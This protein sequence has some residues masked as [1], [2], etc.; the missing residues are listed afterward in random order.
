MIV[1]ESPRE[2]RPPEPAG[3][4][5]VPDL[6]ALLDPRSIAVVGASGD[7]T[8]IGGRPIHFLQ[9]HGYAGDI[10]PVNLRQAE[11]QGLAS[12]RTI[13]DVP[14]A[15]DL[16]I[17]SVPSAQVVDQLQLC[18]D[19]GARFAIVFSSG[20]AE[21][22]REGAAHQQRITD[23]A[24][25]TGLRVL[26]PNSLGVMNVASKVFC[27]FGVAPSLPLPKPGGVSIVSQ[28]GAFGTFTFA[29]GTLRGLPMG[30][31][32]TTGNEA[33]LDFADCVAWLATDPGTQVI[34]GYMEGCKDGRKLMRALEL[35][36]R[37]AKPVVVMKV[38]RTQA[39]A[40][41]AQS[42]TAALAGSDSVFDAVLRQCGA[43]RAATVDEFF[44]TGYACLLGLAPRS[45]RLGVITVSGGAGVLMADAAEEVGLD[46]APLSHE[47]QSKMRA[48]LPFA[49]TRNPVDVTGQSTNDP[50]L[51][52]SFLDAMVEDGDF[53]AIA[54]FQALGGL[55]PEVAD[56]LVAG[57]T[58][59]RAAHPDTPLYISM[60]SE[61]AVTE[62]LE[63]LNIPVFDEPTRM[64]RAIAALAALRRAQAA[65]P[66]PD[67]TLGA[68]AL[69]TAPANEAQASRLLHL[70]GVPMAPFA[71]ARDREEAKAAARS[72]GFPAVVKILSSAIAHKTEAGGVALGL[73]DEDAVADAFDAVTA[74]A[75]TA[76]PDAVVEGVLV[77]PMLGEGVEAIL[78]ARTDPVFGPV[79]MVGLGGIMVEVLGDV[80]FRAAPLSREEAQ[81]MVEELRGKALLAGVRGRPPA[82]RAALVD[83][84][85]AMG[86]FAAA[87]AGR[88]D[89]VEVNPL[90]VRAQ[91]RGVVGLD[92][93]IV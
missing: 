18:A 2:G 83:A 27:T 31:W 17:V 89:S 71:V 52:A 75:R 57:W 77:A 20:F 5:G 21:L 36:R 6:G 93:L 35:A 39:G 32:I 24:R 63:R 86:R 59:I 46:V 42:H 4:D 26:G 30:R 70:A 9:R 16:A 84:I 13:S 11:V 55:L 44:D 1:L 54:C 60:Q 3:G 49:G 7:P 28:S 90:M 43:H 48:R 81:E 37:A 73:T 50:S 34:M 14:Q 88:F 58:A 56:N 45:R 72:L 91:G 15:P 61:R 68:K 53:G 12:Y 23:L 85:L 92:A 33:D 76:F 25:R 38:G 74:G 41:A 10:Y 65:P 62:A 78:A 19:R 51:F 29:S 47:V 67:R 64:V 79:V 80:S 22:G 87:H 66:P 40:A 69:P 82:D 8:R